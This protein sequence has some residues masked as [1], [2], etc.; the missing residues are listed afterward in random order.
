MSRIDR[1]YVSDMFGDCGGTVGILAGSCLSDHSPVVLVSSGGR[2]RT[3]GAMRIPA[4]VQTDS[5]VALQVE[6]I[7]HQLEWQSGSLGATLADGIQQISSLLLSEA[8][9][10]LRRARET[11]RDLHRGIASIQRQLER[12]P[13]SEWLGS[14]LAQAQ[15]ELWDV[16]DWRY[17]FS[18]HRQAASWTQVGDRVTGD[19]FWITG[20]CH[21]REGVRRLR[22]PDGSVESEPEGLRT[23]A[24]QFYQSLLSVEE[25]S[26]TLFGS[27]W[28]VLGSVRRTVTDTMR[29]QLLAPFT[30]LELYVAVRALPRDNCPGAD[31]LL[32]VF[33]VQHWDLLKEGLQ[34]AF[35]EVMNT[36]ILPASLSDGLIYLIPKEGGDREE[37][38]HWRPIT[39]LNSAYKILAK[40]LSLRLQ[41]MLEHLIHTT[42]TGFVK[43]RSIL[44]NIF[45][46][47]EAVS[48]SRLQAHPIAVLLL[49]FEK[50]YDRVDWS[51]LEET[52]QRMGF[53]D[54]WIRGVSALYRSA[55]SWCF[56]LGTGVRGF[57]SPDQSG[58]AALWPLRSSCSLLRL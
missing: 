49:D 8:E 9:D 50:A 51:F 48:L 40:A 54:V 44:D 32:P 39:I 57:L 3:V 6:Q 35:E 16:E 15:Q 52:M 28:R 29:Q 5:G 53:P 17:K 20:P 10:R 7:W 11:E 33:F 25:A 2:S 23:L 14:Q 26:P 1:I 13:D 46:F 18:Y 58:R 37:I 19:F 34:L 27:R 47:W 31:G 41:P 42:Q 21:S 36:G 45:T 43:E 38:R 55:H 12:H 56:W 4:G 22:R 30:E 24:S